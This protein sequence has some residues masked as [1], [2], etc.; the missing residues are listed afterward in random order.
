[1][2]PDRANDKDKP[3]SRPKTQYPDCYLH[4]RECQSGQEW[5]V[6]I[7]D[8]DSIDLEKQVKAW[9]KQEYGDELELSP[10]LMPKLDGD[11]YGKIMTDGRPPESVVC[12]TGGGFYLKAAQ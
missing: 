3:M 11:F 6:P 4:V 8:N 2:V 1:M 7:G 10:P 5:I 12:W 9:V